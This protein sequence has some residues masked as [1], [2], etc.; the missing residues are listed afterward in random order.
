MSGTRKPGAGPGR[1]RSSWI[2]VTAMGALVACSPVSRAATV[3]LS[4]EGGQSAASRHREDSPAQD[5]P[6]RRFD[7]PGGRLED[8]L[9]AFRAVS[10]LSV[11]LADPAIGSVQTA[12]VAGSF[13][14]ERALAQLLQGTGIGFRFTGPEEVTLFLEPVAARVEVNDRPEITSPLYTAPLRDTPQTITVIPQQVIQQQG[15]TTLRDVLRNVP[16]LTMTAGEGGTPAGD[17]LN[18]RGFS[19]RNDVFVDGVR[20]LSPQSRDPFNLE[21][22]EVVKGPGSAFT[23]RGSTGGAINLV[24]KAPVAGLLIGGALNFGTDGTRR[25]SGDVNTPLRFLGQHASLR[26]NLLSHQS[27][28]AGRNAVYNDRWGVAPSLAF[29]VGTPTRL[30][31]SYF[32]LKQSNLS[33][34]GIPWV[35]NTNNVLVAYRDKPAP[36]PRDTFYGFRDRDHERLNA[37]LATARFEHDFSDTLTLREQ[38]RYGRS[39]RDSFAT[40][41]RFAGNNSTVI[42]RELRSWG[43]TDEVFDNQASLGAQFRTGPLHHSVAAGFAY[44][45]EANLRI[46]RNG[47]VAQTTLLDPNP[48]DTYTGTITTSPI[49]GDVRGNTAALY[50]FDTVRLGNHWM[51]NAGWRWERFDA[52]GISTAGAPVGRVDVMNSVR[53]AVTYKPVQAGSVYVSYG[54]SF[55]P[56]LEGL[57]Y[58]TANAAIAP[59]KTYTVE[60]GAKWDL[61]GD[62]L[63]LNGALFRVEKANA[64]TPGVNPGD[65]VQV[66]QG[67]QRVS[68]AELGASGSIARKWKV[69]GAYTFLNSKIVESNTPAEVGE[70]IQNAPAHSLNAWVTYSYRRFTLGAGPRFVGRRF[71][72]NSNTRSVESYWTMDLYA[73]YALNSKL[74]LQLNL[75]NLNDAYYFDRLGGGHVVPGPSRTASFAANFRF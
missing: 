73:S 74:N 26:L 13:T 49:V 19:A 2:A 27:A 22:V 70:R 56:S 61:F 48:D 29:G 66:L 25:F 40:P 65:P 51:L 1:A 52:G 28:V 31:L 37:D 21:Q 32:K 10:G 11:T 24:S 7:L 39:T 64:R 16:G 14:P 9:L 44:T 3:L 69:F 68:G 62:R 67:R 23:G 8:V 5:R 71:G 12:A 53:A 43:T 59:E 55:D 35:P 57:S 72:N 36:V 30:T 54:T 46:T 6:V 47:P 38:F 42:N 58:N 4:P 41:P 20:D 50:G 60:G 17:N 63:L 75:Y 34:Y 45:R 15:A 18:L 33:D